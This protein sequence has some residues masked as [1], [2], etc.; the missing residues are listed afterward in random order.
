MQ[1]FD[2]MWP[3]RKSP[4]SPVA[5]VTPSMVPEGLYWLLRLEAER[6]DQ[7]DEIRSW[8]IE[9]ASNALEDFKRSVNWVL[10]QPGRHPE[11]HVAALNKALAA[12]ERQLAARFSFI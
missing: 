11:D 3:F 7:N 4:P 6:L 10:S 5:T 1:R 8:P 2:A 12:L 9:D